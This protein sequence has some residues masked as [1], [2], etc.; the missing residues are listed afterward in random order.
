MARSRRET[1]DVAIYTTSASSAGL[2]DR[3][4]G[5]A[6]GA[7]R[8]MTLLAREL[9]E[10]GRRVAHIIHAPEDPIPLPSRRL[11][12][13]YR[14]PYAGE[15]R[16]GIVR[17]ASRIWDALGRANA[18]VIVVRSASPVLGVVALYCKLHRRS[19]IFSAANNSDFTLETLGRHPHRRWPY[20]LGVRGADAVVVQSGDQLRLAEQ[21]LDARRVVEI[22]SFVELPAEPV[23]STPQ[24]FLWFGRALDYKRPMHYVDLARA[25]PDASFTMIPLPQ[26]ARAE[27]VAAIHSAA[28]EL[29]N[30]EVLDPLPHARL[31]DLVS[32][33]VAVV[34][35]SRLEGM[36]NAF[37]EAWSRGVPVL[38]FE[39]DPDGVVSRHGLGTAAEGS[40]ERF[41]AG[42]RG[43][44]DNRT[45]RADL[46]ARVRAYVEEQHS[47]ASVGKRWENLIGQL[48]SARGSTALGA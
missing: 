44:W 46:A 14:A 28:G 20:L 30:L 36:P 18:R 10:R 17:E 9:A 13:V 39:F 32:E 23:E 37:L 34:N 19:L 7:E 6:G 40:W 3:A 29:P 5:R 47:P 11:S 12:L 31:M 22:P 26:G 15:G 21:E 38:T 16:A 4:R 8:Q 42:A 33:A 48:I 45:D 1:N 24:R 2:Y 43:L 41:V 25:L 35:T 27:D